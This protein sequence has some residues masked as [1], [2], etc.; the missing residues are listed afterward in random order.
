MSENVSLTAKQSKTLSALLMTGS[1][2]KAAEL[3]NVSERQLYRWL[4]QKPFRDALKAAQGQSLDLA[5]V[6][7]VSGLEVVLWELE[8]VI[9]E[10]KSE[11]VRMRACS[12][13]LDNLVRIVQGQGLEARIAALEEA[14]DASKN[15]TT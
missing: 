4:E 11:S 15:K 8:T 2:K 5:A 12:I 3:S 6:R 13:W 1:V 10:G 7:L 9:Q 14:I